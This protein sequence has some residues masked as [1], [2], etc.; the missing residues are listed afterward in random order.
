MKGVLEKGEDFVATQRDRMLKLLKDKLTEKKIDELPSDL[1]LHKP[2]KSYE[3]FESFHSRSI[4]FIE[5][6]NDTTCGNL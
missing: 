5:F 1:S 6:L 2:K 3:R 4:L